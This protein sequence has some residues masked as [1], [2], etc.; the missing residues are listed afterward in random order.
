MI[1]TV[2]GGLGLCALVPLVP[3][4]NAITTQVLP[5]LAL[6]VGVNSMFSFVHVYFE[7]ATTTPIIVFE[8][9]FVAFKT[10]IRASIFPPRFN[11]YITK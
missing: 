11:W 8:V 3:D 7:H 9:R 6:G 5:F 1:A 2:A 10:I 4:F